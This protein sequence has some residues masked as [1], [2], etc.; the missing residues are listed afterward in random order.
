MGAYLRGRFFSNPVS[1]VV[2]YSRGRLFEEALNRCITVIILSFSI[3]L[4]MIYKSLKFQNHMYFQK[5]FYSLNIDLKILR[6]FVITFLDPS[7]Y[8]LKMFGDPT[9]GTNKYT[10]EHI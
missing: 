10:N 6:P 8:T 7:S 5:H 3:C 1:R 9:I 4:S 2:D